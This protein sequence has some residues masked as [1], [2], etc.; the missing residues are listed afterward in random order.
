MRL[1]VVAGLVVLLAGVA[2][3]AAVRASVA[4]LWLF[5][6]ATALDMTAREA[7]AVAGLFMT[8]AGPVVAGRRAG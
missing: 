1:R 4:P 3:V 6:W 8:V 7:A 2:L 5:E